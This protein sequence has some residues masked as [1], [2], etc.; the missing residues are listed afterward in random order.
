[1]RGRFVG[2]AVLVTGG[3]SGIGRS[4]C[5]A[6]AGEGARVAVV[7][8]DPKNGGKVASEIKKAGGEALFTAADVTDRIEVK[9][10]FD[11]LAKTF[12]GLDI[13]FCNAG[14]GGSYAGGIADYPEEVWDQVV[15]LN[16]TGPYLCTK[17]AVPLLKEKGG[18]SIVV[19]SSVNGLESCPPVAAYAAAKHGA[20]G[21]VKSVAVD[22]ARY[23]IRVN[24]LCPGATITPFHGGNEL[25]GEWR[26]YFE[27]LI[28][29]GHRMAEPSEMAGAV[30]WL[31][32]EEASYVTGTHL[33][34]DGGLRA[35]AFNPTMT[36]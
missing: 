17:Y 28:P 19:T 18:G 22:L 32:S 25:D 36:T 12:G 13:A 2:K 9:A 5:L 20:I 34:V 23:N 3:G 26:K 21:F 6:F 33:V 15:A 10:V 8:I 14:A 30:L 7:D 27:S 16:L 31:C 11:Q 4:C 29:L 1:V 35:K 24:A